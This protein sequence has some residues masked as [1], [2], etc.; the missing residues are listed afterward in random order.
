MH[1][2][3]AIIGGYVGYNYNKWENQLLELLNEKRVEK[4]LAPMKREDVS[5]SYSMITRQKT[6]DSK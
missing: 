4:G 1:L 6:E 3:M 2:G 5:H